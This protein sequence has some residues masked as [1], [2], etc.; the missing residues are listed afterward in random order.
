MG[1]GVGGG[2]HSEGLPEAEQC[3]LQDVTSQ[4]VVV[5]FLSSAHSR[6]SPVAFEIE[7]LRVIKSLPFPPIP[8]PPQQVRVPEIPRWDHVW[9]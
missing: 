6:S 1:R 3:P 2:C 7:D 8:V 5:V 4:W 9:L